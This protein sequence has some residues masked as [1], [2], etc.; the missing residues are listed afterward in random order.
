MVKRGS[1]KWKWGNK[2]KMKGIREAA[3][4]K[5]QKRNGEKRKWKN[6]MR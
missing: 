2:E 5:K 4:K 1:G 6:E 3:N